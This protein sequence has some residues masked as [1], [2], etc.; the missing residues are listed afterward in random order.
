[1][2]AFEELERLARQLIG[3]IHQ[4]IQARQLPAARELYAQSQRQLH[5][6]DTSLETRE[7]LHYRL[8]LLD[9][10]LKFMDETVRW[11][12]E[13]LEAVEAELAV[14]ART[15]LGE[16][17]RR[18]ALLVVLVH[19]DQD[20][21]R[22]LTEARYKELA[23]GIPDGSHSSGLLQILSKWAFKHRHLPLLERAFEEYLINPDQVMGAAK[24][25]RINLMYQLTLGKATR[26]DVLETIKTLAIVPQV[27]E[28]TTLIWPAC[29]KAGLVDAELRAMLAARESHILAEP[30]SPASERRTKFLRTGPAG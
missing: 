6:L 15:P 9:C 10:N 5:R 14:P 25:Q 13:S 8:Y 17:E 18:K 30:P 11:N 22:E 28:F 19:A 29:E 7:G 21:I 23:A 2:T 12:L 27:I 24:W 1:M 26:R 20:N 4:A 16:I 3:P